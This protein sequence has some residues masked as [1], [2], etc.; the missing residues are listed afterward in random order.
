MGQLI[1]SDGNNHSNDDLIN[2]L[3]RRQYITSPDVERV[4][5]CVDRGLYY[6]SDNKA[7]A[8]RDSAWLYEKVHLSAPS[9][10][11]IVLECLD[12]CMGNK[13]LNIGSG[14]GYFSTVA[15]LL[16]GKC[17]VNFI[18]CTLPFDLLN[19]YQLFFIIF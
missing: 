6:T 3:I 5:R 17:N 18:Y 14:V 2:T 19:D 13:F 4:F 8:Y 16:L 7:D 9:I 12:L 11:A 15:G 10:Y 1:S